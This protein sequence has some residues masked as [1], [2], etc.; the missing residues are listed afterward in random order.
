MIGPRHG[1][2]LIGIGFMIAIAIAIAMPGQVTAQEALRV[3][4]A[5]NNRPLSWRVASASGGFEPLM[6]KALTEELRRPLTLVWYEPEYDRESSL[7]LEV[8]ALLSA[9][10]CDMVASYMLYA[11]ALGA[12]TKPRARTPDYDGAKRKREREFVTLGNLIASAPYQ[13]SALTVILGPAAHAVRINSPAD[14][15]TLRV[16][17]TAGSLGGVL[18]AGY[19][20]GILRDHLQSVGLREDLLA[21]LEKGEFEVAFAPLNKFDEYRLAHPATALRASGYVHPFR[22]NLGF[23][24]REEKHELIQAV[25]RFVAEASRQGRL[26]GWARE[27]GLSYVTPSAPAIQLELST[28]SLQQGLD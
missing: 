25:N 20:N 8:N 2:R 4:V 18:L 21:A 15:Q 28:R 6:L 5:E 1:A 22:F 3:C 7:A 24:A 9:G 11:P 26:A 16:G 12:P 10:L 14:L 23:V 17:V 19:R 27:S 13:A